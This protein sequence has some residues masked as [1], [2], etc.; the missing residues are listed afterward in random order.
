M[1]LAIEHDGQPLETDWPYLEVTPANPSAWLPPTPSPPSFTR[2]GN[3]IAASWE[4][5]AARI[6]SGT[7]LVILLKLSKSFFRPK[8]GVVQA[9]AGDPPDPNRRHAVVAV[10]LGKAGP[11]DAILVRNSW[12]EKW[13][14][15]G[16][17]WLTASFVKP[18]LY[19][20]AV[21]EGCQD[22]PANTPGS[23]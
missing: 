16:Y 6:E 19:D 22:V 4:T 1:L 17:A 3:G 9:V 13:G 12:G 8:G 10:G 23:A 11:E 14:N 18:R 2:K 5:L 7:P 15:A 21:F 20:M